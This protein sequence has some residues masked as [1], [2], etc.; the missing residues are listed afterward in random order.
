M[1][2]SPAEAGVLDGT[3]YFE[4]IGLI[5]GSTGMELLHC[6]NPVMTIGDA[7]SSS[8]A[9]TT[10]GSNM[11]M[12]WD[13]AGTAHCWTSWNLPDSGST[14]YSKILFISYVFA[15]RAGYHALGIS[16]NEYSGSEGTTN[17]YRDCYSFQP[18]SGF[19]EYN[20]TGTTFTTIAT[21]STMTLTNNQLYDPI[22]GTAIYAEATGNVQKCFLKSTGQWV[23]TLSTTSSETGSNG[24]KSVATYGYA[25]TWTVSPFM[26]WGLET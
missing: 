23:R 24:W 4:Q 8:T 12:T 22:M 1:T 19:I 9:L 2:Y 11:K 5:G 16:E 3:D 13:E 10:S 20:N 14:T 17:Y 25:S 15:Y 7:Y 6:F 26:V 18:V 21:D